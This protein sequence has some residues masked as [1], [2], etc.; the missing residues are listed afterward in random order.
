M[1]APKVYISQ[2]P[3]SNKRGW[4]PNFSP[5][6]QYGQL[7]FV[8]NDDVQVFNLPDKGLV[9]AN[10]VLKSFRPDVDF[11]V[12]P[13]TGDPIALYSCLFAIMAQGHKEVTFLNWQRDP[14]NRSHG[15]YEPVTLDMTLIL[16]KDYENE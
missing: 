10:E 16:P 7:S 14:Q 8:F 13:S 2:R 3:G 1:T 12:W 6:I 15:Y 11:L 4:V 9:L 5:A